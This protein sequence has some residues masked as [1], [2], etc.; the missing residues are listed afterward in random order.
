MKNFST[1]L[2]AAALIAAGASSE[3]APVAASFQK[4]KKSSEINVRSLNSSKASM[5][6]LPARSQKEDLEALPL[7]VGLP[8][9][10]EGKDLARANNYFALSVYGELYASQEVGMIGNVALTDDKA[11]LLD[12]FAGMKTE[13]Y[14]VGDRNGDEIT[15]S[16]PQKIYQ[17]TYEDWYTDP[18]GET[19]VTDW[20][21]AFKCTYTDDG[22]NSSLVIDTE[23]PEIKF[24]LGADGSLTQEGDAYIALVLGADNDEGV[25]SLEWTGF[26]DAAIVYTEVTEQP[27][28]LPEGALLDDWIMAAGE[29]MRLVKAGFIDGDLYIQGLLSTMPQGVVKGVKSEDEDDAYI[30]SVQYVGPDYS[31][32]HFAY[33]SPALYELSENESGDYESSYTPAESV[34]MRFLD[35][36]DYKVIMTDPDQ[37]VL[38]SSLPGGGLWMEA[39]DEP[40][41]QWQDMSTPMT[42][43]DPEII[44]Y[45]FY[46]ALEYGAL[47][48]YIPILSMDGR[49]LKADRYY[50]NFYFDDELYTFYPDEYYN[51]EA[52][53][54]NIPFGFEDF[55]DFISYGEEN[56]A[57]IYARGFN[58]IGLQSVYLNEDGTETRS[59]MVTYELEGDGVELV[60]TSVEKSVEWYDLAGRRIA[61]PS[62][63][64]AIRRTIL[65]DGTVKTSKVIVK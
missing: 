59:E 44:E 21:Y 55:M 33:M 47:T 9:G 52:P 22:E 29:E 23:N 27:T 15:F 62:Q 63:G 58:K 46:D 32:D 19:M 10:V 56:Q 2:I 57:V 35:D 3:A 31:Y 45:Q 30:F 1:V 14:L 18:T 12:P 51:L 65:E 36:G 8:E 40:A 5:R 53:M 61:A 43:A 26:A 25:Y 60:E 11:Y 6:N 48:Y 38:F 50:Y 4:A 64:I 37:A 41:F 17:E 39:Y 16:F 7:V 24:T 49:M 42:P 13:S 54:T 28:L 34:T 20:Y